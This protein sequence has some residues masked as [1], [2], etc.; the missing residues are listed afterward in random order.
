LSTVRNKKIRDPGFLEGNT[1]RNLFCNNGDLR[2]E[3]S[4]ETFFVHRL[5]KNLGYPD[6][7]VRTKESI[8]K[9][10]IPRGHTTER[11]APDYV[12]L[13]SRNL[14]VIVIDAKHP[15]ENLDKWVYQPTGYAATLNR[16]YPSGENPVQYAILTNGHF[17]TVY[18]WDSEIPV[19]HLRFEDFVEGN[20]TFA[21]LRANLAYSIFNRVP[22]TG[23]AFEFYRPE[24]T[25]L[26][27]TFNKCHDLIWKKEKVGPTRAFYEFVKIIFVKMREDRKIHQKLRS[28]RTIMR[29]DFIFSVHWI[30]KNEDVTPNPFDTVLFKEVR[31]EIEEQIRKSLKK[32]IFPVGDK[33]YLSPSTTKEVVR[34]LEH[35]DLYGID[36]DLNGRMFETFLSATIRGKELGQF[37]TPRPIVRYMTTTAQMRITSGDVPYVLDGCCGTGGFLIEAMADL[38]QKIDRVENLSS[39]EKQ[40]MMSLVTDNRLYGIEANE[41]LSRVAR[42]NMYLHG[43]GGSKIFHMDALDKEMVIEAGLDLETEDGRRELRSY[44]VDLNLRFDYVLTNP[45]FSMLYHSSDKTERRILAGYQIARTKS[46]KLST[47][48]KSNV[49]FLER[50]LDLLQPGGELLTIIDDTVLN[51]ESGAHHREFI[52]KNFIIRQVIS[53]P[54]NAF[55]KAD[56]NIKTSILHLRK[57]RPGE[58]QGHVF[59]AI[60]N[61]VGHND[62]KVDTPS[63]DN[64]GIVASLYNEWLKSGHLDPQIIYNQHPDEPLGCPLQIFTVAPGHINRDRLDAFYYAPELKLLRQSIE[65]AVRQGQVEVKRG[66]D[67]NLIDEVKGKT[68]NEL[69]GQPFKYFEIT[70]VTSDGAILSWREDLYENLPTRAGLRVKTNDVIFAKNNSSRGTTIIIPSYFEGALVTTGFLGIR[71]KDLDEAMLLWAVLSSEALRRQIYYLA[72]TASQPEIRRNIFE[73]EFLLPFPKEP[74]R[75]RVLDHARQIWEARNTISNTLGELKTLQQGLLTLS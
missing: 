34:M 52:F 50:Y 7:R 56:S 57:K 22:V 3:S 67:F 54:F 2:N 20:E 18:P 51:G 55:F 16:R 1:L 14:P 62:H 17:F 8:E 65:E 43:D 33:I 59:M 30:E 70:D 60:T 63:R 48:E 41:D 73:R 15:N 6:S 11:Y 25:V 46:G 38:L 61:N 44:F 35:F 45:P 36:E 53:L 49:L 69:L 37:F 68:A 28:G 74:H 39:T 26:T 66:H 64:L 58:T 40:G 27:K 47:S 9:L 24:L 71:S 13:D 19:F 23:I 10:P 12:L 4:V 21:F 5:L 32:R 42:L 75:S 29:D 72:I 31:D